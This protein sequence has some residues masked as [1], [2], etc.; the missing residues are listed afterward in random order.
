[1]PTR[2]HSGPLKSSCK[3]A[4]TH[5][6][7]HRHE[8]MYICMYILIL[9]EFLIVQHLPIMISPSIN[10]GHPAGRGLIQNIRCKL[11]VLTHQAH[12]THTHTHIVLL[13]WYLILSGYRTYIDLAICSYTA[14]QQHRNSK[15]QRS[16]KLIS[17]TVDDT[18]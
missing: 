11:Q 17:I 15:K 14:F 2:P 1:M 13:F 4:G 16:F 7:M 18:N 9:N 8:Y 3:I 12:F 5:T 10:F 6:H